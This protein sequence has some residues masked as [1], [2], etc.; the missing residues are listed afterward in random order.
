M[1][2]YMV[3]GSWA[4]GVGPGP[5][6]YRLHAVACVHLHHF[7][8]HPNSRG[9][10]L[11]C[12]TCAQPMYVAVDLEQQCRDRDLCCPG[13]HAWRHFTCVTLSLLP[14]DALYGTSIL[15]AT[16]I[17]AVRIMGRGFRLET[18]RNYAKIIREPA[19]QGCRA[20]AIFCASVCL[21]FLQVC[22]IAP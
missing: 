10:V 14:K 21:H 11:I 22:S 19:V 2:Y 18:C 8:Y 16:Y 15:R 7:L 4:V 12:G 9:K 6:P 17:H 1:W 13:L 20:D 3:P 5:A